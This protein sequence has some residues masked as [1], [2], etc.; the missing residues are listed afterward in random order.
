[1]SAAI[2][3]SGWNKNEQQQNDNSCNICI[4]VLVMCADPP[5]GINARSTTATLNIRLL[6]INDVAT[7]THN[8]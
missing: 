8:W 1:M 3:Y 5:G 2:I 4:L 7:C 6:E